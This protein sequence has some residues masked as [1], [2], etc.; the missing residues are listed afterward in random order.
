[1]GFQQGLS[2]LN[3]SSKGLDAV[4]NN[5]ANAGTIGFKAATA[6]FADVYAA[7][8]TGGTVGRAVGQGGSVMNVSQSFTQGNVT[9]SANPLDLAINGNGFLRF[10]PSLADATSSYSRNGQLHLDTN[11][12][13][14]NAQDQFLNAYVSKDGITIDETAAVPIQISSAQLPPRVTGFGN[15]ITAGEGGLKLGINL[16]VRDKRSAI[17]EAVTL[18]AAAAKAAFDTGSGKLYTDVAYE[19]QQAAETAVLTSDQ[20]TAFAKAGEAIAATMTIAAK[21][22][23][24]GL[25]DTTLADTAISDFSA[26]VAAAMAADPASADLTQRPG[27]LIETA[28]ATLN[29]TINALYPAGSDKINVKATS[30]YVS[31]KAAA[32]KAVDANVAATTSSAAL[33]TAIDDLATANANLAGVDPLDP[34]AVAAATAAVTTATKAEAAARTK[35]TSDL[36]LIAVAAKD[37]ATAAADATAPNMGPTWTSLQK[38]DFASMN[39]NMYNYSTSASIFDQ[40]GESHILT[41]YFVRSGINDG[42]GEVIGANSWTPHFVIDNK[43]EIPAVN[44]LNAATQTAGGTVDFLSG[45]QL[46]KSTNSDLWYLDLAKAVNSSGVNVPLTEFPNDLFPAPTFGGGYDLSVNLGSA[47]QFGSGY[48]VNSLQQDGYSPGRISGMAVDAE[49][50]ISARYSNGQTQLQGRVTLSTFQNPNGLV[51]LGNNM[52]GQSAGSGPALIGSPNTGAKGTIQSGAVEEANVDLTQELVAMIVLQR[53]Y[54]ANAQTI[55]TQDSVLQTLVN[56]R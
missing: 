45:G 4:G 12:Y 39:P 5:I 48:D 25:N 13:L 55:K 50:N 47:T 29:S 38:W 23:A 18:G 49:G 37:A 53:S 24:A 6:Q 30:A 34:A 8:L 43:Y 9:S 15:T 35:S 40:R 11:G 44:S 22:V 28:A 42:T 26:A 19:A 20:A 17:P 7:A 46:D 33:Q 56:L 52:W 1:M 21:T 32:I 54:Q 36:N 27:A 2:G 10:Q 51:P 41:M 14:V 3:I 16:D 31:A